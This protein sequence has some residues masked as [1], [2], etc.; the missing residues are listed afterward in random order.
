MAN[1]RN[2]NL[3]FFSL[4]FLAIASSQGAPTVSGISGTAQSRSTITISGSGFGTG[5]APLIWDD[6]ETGTLGA[7]LKAQPQIGNWN[8]GYAVY[9]NATAHSGTQSITK[10]NTQFGNIEYDLP[11]A[12]D[13]F[14][15]ETFWFRYYYTA[16]DSGGVKLMQLWGNYR[17]GDYNPGAFC[18]GVLSG[19][20][21]PWWLTYM[22]LE[23]SGQ[24]NYTE[25]TEPAQNVW[26]RFEI[27]LKQSGINVADGRVTIR[28]DGTTVYDRNP[29]VTR[30][31]AGH[32]WNLITML[33]GMANFSKPQATWI[34][35]AYLNNTWARI[36]IGDNAVYANAKHREILP[37]TSWSSNSIT[38]IFNQGSFGAGQTVYLFVV[39]ST[40]TPSPG[41]PITIGGT[42]TRLP[43]PSNLRVQ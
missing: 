11:G 18:D 35:D 27:I 7:Q 8:A 14:F 23:N 2:L 3:A 21:T 22:A 16:G 9:T 5:K 39:D 43:P 32:Y 26:H 40:D 37:A 15:Y 13:N 6:F 19:T 31:Q 4:G 12:T 33:G 42:S 1:R 28:I 36:E 38:A 41:Y 29:V 17:V 25:F 10:A 34:D 30:E 24:T 20:G